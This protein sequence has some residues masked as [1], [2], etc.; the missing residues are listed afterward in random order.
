MYIYISRKGEREREIE[1]ERGRHG[2]WRGAVARHDA[3]A[4]LHDRGHLSSV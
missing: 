1:R 2:R 3:R 4:G